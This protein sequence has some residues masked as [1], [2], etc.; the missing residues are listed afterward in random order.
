LYL[1]DVT[2]VKD[3]I[4]RTIFKQLIPIY[5]ERMSAGDEWPGLIEDAGSCIPAY[6][7]PETFPRKMNFM[8]PTVLS[9]ELT[10]AQFKVL[11]AGFFPY[12]GNFALGRLDG[13]ELAGAVGLKE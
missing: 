13:R 9:R 7:H 11:R 1:R 10:R 3:A 2:L 5:E 8:D 4:Y 6:L 12:T